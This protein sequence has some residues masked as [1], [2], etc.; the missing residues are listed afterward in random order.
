LHFNSSR[1]PVGG[2]VDVGLWD[3]ILDGIEDRQANRIVSRKNRDC[4]FTVHFNLRYSG[5]RTTTGH[6][7]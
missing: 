4:F 6:A 3:S 1:N 2:Y 5:V 7:E